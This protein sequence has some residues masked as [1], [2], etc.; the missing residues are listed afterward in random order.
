MALTESYITTDE[1]ITLNDG[2]TIT[3][4]SMMKNSQTKR[5]H[6]YFMVKRE[7]VTSDAQN[8]GVLK[9]NISSTY[10]NGG[11]FVGGEWTVS[12]IGYLY[13][14]GKPTNIQIKWGDSSNYAKVYIDYKYS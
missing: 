13:I 14:G 1:F 12:G 3:S 8:I 6:G 7:A 4:I 11:C 10:I 9:N 5:I 2:F